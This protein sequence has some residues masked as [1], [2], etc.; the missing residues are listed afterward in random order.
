VPYALL[1]APFLEALVHL[2]SH[3]DCLAVKPAV[4]HNVEVENVARI[5]CLKRLSTDKALSTELVGLWAAETRILVLLGHIADVTQYW[6][7]KDALEVT[8][9]YND[10]LNTVPDRLQRLD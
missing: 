4:S 8:K 5:A 9:I 7:A 6:D 2:Q 3:L 1:S 10:T